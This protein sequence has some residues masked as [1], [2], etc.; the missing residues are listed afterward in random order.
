MII[1]ELMGAV[2][3]DRRERYAYWLNQAK[4]M[5]D[6]EIFGC[7]SQKNMTFYTYP[8]TNMN[9]LSCSVCAYRLEQGF[10]GCSMCDYENGDLMHQAF[11]AELMSRNRGLYA[12]AVKKS[13]QNV[14]GPAAVPNVFE[15]VSSYDVFS[16]QE[17]PE[18]VFYELF[19]GNPLF[20]KKPFS[21][22]L[23]TRASSVTPEKLSLVRKYIPQPNR[24]MI[25]CGVETADEWVRNHWLNKGVSNRQIETAVQQIHAAGF[26][27]S[28]DV[29]IGIPGFT[30]Q[31]SIDQFADTVRWLDEIGVDQIIMLPLNRKEKTLQGVIYAYLRDDRSLC[32][33]GLAQGEHTGV[34][35]LNTIFRAIHT[36]LRE[37]PERISKLNLAQVFSYQNSV[38]NITAYNDKGCSCNAALIQALSDYQ[39]K[40]NSTAL[41]EAYHFA[42][43]SRHACYTQYLELLERQKAYGTGS[44]MRT[45]VSRLAPCVWPVQYADKAAAFERELAHLEGGD[46]PCQGGF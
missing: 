6:R 16:D 27:S 8:G 12:K 22:I 2:W 19:E 45:L 44:V 42:A 34:P 10:S 9:L 46:D 38:R 41:Q 28:A 24:V 15:L 20:V 3:K 36:V 23:E 13:F 1:R 5:T 35:W 31:Q 37:R 33:K 14:R 4:M 30:E 39:K 21:Y 32:E 7:V 43:S 17:F 25:E 18:E 29:L 11:M 40:R 26:K